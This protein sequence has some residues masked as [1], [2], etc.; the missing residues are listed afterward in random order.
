[1]TRNYR[2]KPSPKADS[3]FFPEARASTSAVKEPQAVVKSEPSDDSDSEYEVVDNNPAV[4]DDDPAA[5]DY[6]DLYG[7]F[8]DDEDDDEDEDEDAGEFSVAEQL[9][10]AIT[11][12]RKV[13]YLLGK[14]HIV[15]TSFDHFTVPTNTLYRPF[16]SRLD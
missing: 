10:P 4:A 11:A 9:P 16:G 2:L 12:Q 6:E 14:T 7:D 3:L 15:R 8:S 1:M 5:L 13:E